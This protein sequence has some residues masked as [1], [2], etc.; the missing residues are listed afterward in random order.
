MITIASL[1]PFGV[2]S[3]AIWEFAAGV[4]VVAFTIALIL[5]GVSL[6]KRLIE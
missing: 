3:G 2:N 1:S 6:I 4:L 5:M